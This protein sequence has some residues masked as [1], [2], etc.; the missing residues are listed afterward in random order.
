M[1]FTLVQWTSNE[2]KI[3]T[4]NRVRSVGTKTS[5]L[6]MVPH[7]RNKVQN[8]KNY[9]CVESSSILIYIIT[10]DT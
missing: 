1:R 8:S 3:K 2:S 7:V 5:S 9:Y 6:S 4:G 10:G